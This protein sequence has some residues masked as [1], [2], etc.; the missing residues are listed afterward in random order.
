MSMPMSP[1]PSAETCRDRFTWP[2]A[3][4]SIWNMPVGSGALFDPAQLFPS[5]ATPASVF[6]DTEYFYATTDADP[7]T[8]WYH[9]GWWA[10]RT[11]HCTVIGPLVGEIQFPANATVTMGGNN[12]AALLLPDNV[13][14]LQLQ[15]LYRC[16]VGSPILAQDFVMHRE[17]ESILEDGMYG[18]HGGSGLSSIGGSLRLGE[19]LPDSPP[20]RHALKLELFAN[21]YFN[22]FPC[23]YWPARQ[24]DGYAH[25]ESNP[26]FYNG[27]NPYMG[28]GALLAVPSDLAPALEAQMSTIPGA[29]LLAA[30]TDYGGV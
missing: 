10:G 24:C 17:N 23:F 5:P 25:N 11:S 29:K 4:T 19:L 7:W 6:L 12:A 28:P 30:L 13:T 18:A 8:P 15:P 3:S 16:K 9:Q 26:L 27:T 2:F 1:E 22:S 21:H 20:I 14:L